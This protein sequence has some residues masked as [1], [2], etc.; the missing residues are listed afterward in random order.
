MAGKLETVLDD[1]TAEDLHYLG[2]A[3]KGFAL[4]TIVLLPLAVLTVNTGYFTLPLM[5]IAMCLLIAG[6]LDLIIKVKGGAGSRC[7]QRSAQ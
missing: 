7:R 1:L 6:S 3:K 5:F 2:H 4:F